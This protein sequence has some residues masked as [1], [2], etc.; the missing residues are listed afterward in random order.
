MSRR[1][2]RCTSGRSACWT[3]NPGTSALAQ[4]TFHFSAFLIL[5]V[6]DGYLWKLKM[7]RRSLGNASAT[8]HILEEEDAH[9]AASP[10]AKLAFQAPG[11]WE[12]ALRKPR[13]V[14]RAEAIGRVVATHE[15]HNQSLAL[16][17]AR[18]LHVTNCNV[19]KCSRASD[20]AGC[21]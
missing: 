21:L 5:G 10:R 7:Q 2:C 19:S 17:I 3:W 14:E 9:T 1:H 13:H 8:W 6:F 16:T 4:I 20:P 18:V 12:P 15:M 11:G